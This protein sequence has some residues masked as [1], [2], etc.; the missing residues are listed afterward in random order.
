MV[1]LGTLGGSRSEATALN[2]RGD[3]VGVSETGTGEAHATLWTT[4]LMDS[5]SDRL[6]LHDVQASSDLTFVL[7]ASHA[8]DGD[9]F[10]RW[11]SAFSDSQSFADRSGVRHC[12]ECLHRRRCHVRWD[13]GYVD[14]RRAHV[15]ARNSQSATHQ[16]RMAQRYATLGEL[17]AIAA[18]SLATHEQPRTG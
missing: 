12:I 6:V 14:H 4:K 5:P 7:D 11:S 18:G 9:P 15:D 10:S 2:A 16:K 13:H 8:A 1:D 3:V 17:T